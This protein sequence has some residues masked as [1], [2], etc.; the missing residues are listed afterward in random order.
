MQS[1]DLMALLS[2]R[3]VCRPAL[4]RTP[5]TTRGLYPLITWQGQTTQGK[6]FSSPGIHKRMNESETKPVNDPQDLRLNSQVIPL[7]MH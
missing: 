7:R 2:H 4:P 1:L 3:Y 6:A 5:P